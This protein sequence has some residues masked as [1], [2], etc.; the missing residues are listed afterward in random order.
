[1]KTA[2][3]VTTISCFRLRQLSQLTLTTTTKTKNCSGDWFDLGF[4]VAVVCYL[5]CLTTGIGKLSSKFGDDQTVNV[6]FLI[7][8]KHL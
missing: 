1:M 8:I 2:L 6:L 3:S 4:K 7:F 5:N